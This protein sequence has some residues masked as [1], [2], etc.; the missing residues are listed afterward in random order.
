MALWNIDDDYDEDADEDKD[1]D[2]YDDNEEIL[3]IEDEDDKIDDDFE[4][5]CVNCSAIV[6]DGYQCEVCGWLVG[7]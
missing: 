6:D 7:V 2:L 5:R 3:D 4:R 1:N